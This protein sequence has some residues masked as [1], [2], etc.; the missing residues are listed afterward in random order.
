L[1]VHEI[2]KRK[3]STNSV[4]NEGL[5]IVLEGDS[6]IFK[7]FLGKGFLDKWNL[8]SERGSAKKN[9]CD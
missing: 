1:G 3:F 2:L 8:A 6:L 4:V 7:D 9:E 5:S